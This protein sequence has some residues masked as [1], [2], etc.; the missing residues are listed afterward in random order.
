MME[1]AIR[2]LLLLCFIIITV[3]NVDYAGASNASAFYCTAVNISSSEIRLN[4]PAADE[5]DTYRY[6]V[7]YYPVYS[8]NIS[9]YDTVPDGKSMYYVSGLEEQTMYQFSLLRSDQLGRDWSRVCVV[10]KRTGQQT[11]YPVRGLLQFVLNTTT[12]YITWKGTS[13]P[14]SNVSYR[15]FMDWLE[16]RVPKSALVYDGDK[17]NAVVTRRPLPHH[18]KFHVNVVYEER[19]EGQTTAA[20]PTHFP[21]HTPDSSDITLKVK[22]I[23]FSWNFIHL[24]WNPVPVQQG[25]L[26][27]VIQYKTTEEEHQVRTSQDNVIL[28]GLRQFTTYQVRVRAQLNN[29]EVIVTS[30]WKSVRTA[31]QDECSSGKHT[32]DEDA[33]CINMR[34]SY[35]CM[36]REGLIG[37]GHSCKVPE[38][39]TADLLTYC[40]AHYE[41]GIMW[42]RTAH[43]QTQIQRCPKD[44]TG[45]ASRQCSGPADSPEWEIPDMSQ[46]VTDAIARIHKELEGPDVKPFQ[47]ATKLE[48]V[49]TDH[50]DKKPLYAGDLRLIVSSVKILSRD[51]FRRGLGE[52]DIAQAKTLA[53]TILQSSSNILDPSTRDSWK[54]MPKKFAER[55]ANDLIESLDMMADQ[56]AEAIGDSQTLLQRSP[57]IVLSVRG[58]G[59]NDLG[60]QRLPPGEDTPEDF[61]SRVTVPG[62]VLQHSSQGNHKRLTFVSF[63]SIKDLLQISSR[64]HVDSAVVSVTLKPLKKNQFDEPITITIRRSEKPHSGVPACVFLNGT[65]DRSSRLSWSG[66]GCTVGKT[67]STHVQCHCRHLTS[68]AVLMQVSDGGTSKVEPEHHFAL[69]LITYIGISLSLVGLIV[70]FMTFTF[71]KFLRSPRHFIHANL[72]LSLAL[73]EMVFLLGIDRTEYQ[74]ACK[75]LAIAMHYLFLVAFAWMALEGVILYLMLVKVFHSSV[76]GRKTKTIFF[77]CGWGLPVIVVAVSATVYHE[78]YGTQTFCWLS[79]ERHFIWAFVAPVLA[80]ILF[81]FVC[82]GR[83]FYVMA[84]RGSNGRKESKVAKIRYWARSCCLLTCILGVTWLLGVFFVNEETLVMAY[85][86][87]ILN[88]LQGVAIFLL[89]C[90]G[91]HKIRAAYRR[92]VKCHEDPL[93]SSSA[94]N[95]TT[96]G[97]PTSSAEKRKKKRLVKQSTMSSMLKTPYINPQN[98]LNTLPPPNE[99][100]RD[101]VN[102]N[103][104]PKV[105][106]DVNEIKED[107]GNCMM[108]FNEDNARFIEDSVP[109]NEDSVPFNHEEVL[110]NGKEANV[111]DYAIQVNDENLHLKDEEVHLN[112]ERVYFDGKNIQFNDEEAHFDDMEEPIEMTSAIIESEVKVALL[113]HGNG[114]ANWV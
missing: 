99:T 78:G 48:R 13:V 3:K 75:I 88:A 96:R 32:C 79:L 109:F 84:K 97:D 40:P 20:T 69:T 18:V 54:Y 31:D 80:V 30:S 65:K 23:I 90:I 87:S 102:P 70:V 7:Q 50:N 68:F 5:E 41:N 113:K 44:S 9:M 12:A 22:V 8:P 26:T 62:S 52:A 19:V 57:N 39:S 81:N 98:K 56:L 58:I 4:W 11:L 60:E 17:R 53:K 72:A 107:D 101:P 28:S 105:K 47:V 27:Y 37:D 15:V 35:T 111:N 10:Y 106:V 77:A 114:T 24:S 42:P 74:V 21:V 38:F 6:V 86:F 29:D 34:G 85:L 93:S 94:G 73:A 108:Q 92:M 2:L 83:T 25:D 66:D 89:H 49:T 1:K 45:V 64:G 36:C 51:A 14:G 43:A 16:H 82:L 91:D 71:M 76:S 100:T 103:P 61:L 63:K 55:E 104:V 112:N 33:E 67:N 110:S 46:C 59:A 95:K